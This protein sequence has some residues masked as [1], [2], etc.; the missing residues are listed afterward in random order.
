MRRIKGAIGTA[1]GFCMAA[2][3]TCLIL[4]LVY[5]LASEQMPALKSIWPE[6][7]CV[8]GFPENGSSCASQEIATL[9]DELRNSEQERKRASD[10]IVGDRL[11]Y[12][13]GE[14]LKDGV[15]LAAGTLYQD[16]AA[17]TGLIQSYCWVVADISGL[18]PRAAVAV[19][20]PT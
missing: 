10:A 7:R 13:Q 5:S 6:L 15:Y 2:G 11:V 4:A 3:F 18:D 17:Q 20:S 16:T 9:E 19:M 14:K 1:I 12:T 8:A